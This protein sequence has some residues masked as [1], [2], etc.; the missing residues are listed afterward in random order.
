MKVT[1]TQEHIERGQRN[2]AGSCPIALALREAEAQSGS[3]SVNEETAQFLAI[4]SDGLLVAYQYVLSPEAQAFV[5]SFD[6]GRPVA[7]FEAEIR[8]GCV[9]DGLQAA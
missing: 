7:P 4:E 2:S 8:A 3:W 6:A 5:S 9:W 1:I